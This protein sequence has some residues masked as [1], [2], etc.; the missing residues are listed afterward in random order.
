MTTI[1][2]AI[3]N[4]AHT[5]NKTYCQKISVYAENLTSAQGNIITN[6]HVQMSQ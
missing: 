3:D 5:H 6:I 1:I 2:F 4:N